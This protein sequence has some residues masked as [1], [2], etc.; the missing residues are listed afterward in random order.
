MGLQLGSYQLTN[1]LGRGGMGEIWR[2]SHRFLKRPA[3][4]KLIRPETLGGRA[5]GGAHTLL[6]RFEREVQ[7][8]ALLTSAHTVRIYDYGHEANGTFYYAMELLTG[9]NFDDLVARTGPLPPARVVHLLTQA[10]ESLAEAH[11]NGLVHRDV[12]PANLHLCR[13]G[14]EHDYVKVLD[15]GLVLPS[16]PMSTEIA[17][18]TAENFAL[19]TPAFL[20]PE[21]A[22]GTEEVGPRSDVYALGCVAYWLLTG[23]LPFSGNT[24]LEVALKHVRDPPEPPSRR[25]GTPLPRE[26]EKVVLACLAKSPGQR[27]ADARVLSRMLGESVPGERWEQA[28]ATRWWERHHPERFAGVHEEDAPIGV[29]TAVATP[30]L[31]AETG[32]SGSRGGDD[33]GEL[34]SIAVLPLS[35][36]MAD[37]DQRHFVLGMHETLI[38]ELSRIGALSVISR[39]SVIGYQDTSKRLGEIARE[40]GVSAVMEGSVLRAGESVRISLRLVAARNE[41]LLWSESYDGELRNVFELQCRIAADVAARVK[42]VLT[43]EEQR[44]VA[45]PRPIDPRALD[46][47]FRAEALASGFADQELRSAIQAFEKALAIDPLCGAAHAGMARCYN[48]LATFGWEAPREVFPHSVAALKKALALDPELASAHSALGYARLFFEWDFDG[49]RALFEK[50]LSLEPSNVSALCDYGRYL[51]VVGDTRRSSEVLERAT[52][53]DPHS[54]VTRLWV[55]WALYM[56][57]RF[58]EAARVFQAILDATPPFVYARLWLAAALAAA[59][60]HGLAAARAAEVLASHGDSPDNNL[61]CVL[62]NTLGRVGDSAGAHRV[63]ERLQA[64]PAG[65][66]V[67]PAFPAVIHAALGELDRAM[68]N[69]RAGYEAPSMIMVYLERHPF[70]DPLRRDPRFLELCLRMRMASKRPEGIRGQ[71]S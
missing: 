26:L 25:L 31:A 17:K 40:L 22:L 14:L 20:A 45:R 51:A 1:L 6:L 42:V 38:S 11:H 32:S 60:K 2:A 70:L 55:G 52:V 30:R 7:A 63:L 68:E 54:P 37:P 58:D 21:A 65:R 43:P 59:G 28:D 64:A 41:R 29:V 15:F 24:P 36:L 8:T 13:Q 53:L 10:C 12:K 48:N 27:P 18:L 69:L 35:N 5:A 49:P 9:C 71:L 4:V 39:T 50:A 61:Q 57:A 46:Q 23:T 47:F 56:A 16:R 19:G 33:S 44:H 3:A 34:R 62:G 66:W 67:D